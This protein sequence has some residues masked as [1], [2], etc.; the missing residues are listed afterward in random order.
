MD[1]LENEN[2]EIELLLE[3]VHRKYGYDFRSYAKASVRRRIL[4]RLSLSKLSSISEMQHKILYEQSFFETLLIDLSISVT[5]MFRDPQF[6]KVLREEV[7]PNLK[8]YP[9]IKIWNAGCST[10]EEAYSMAILLLEE[11]LYKRAQIYATDFNTAVLEKAKAGAFSTDHIKDYTANY[12]KSGGRKSFSD[13]YTIKQ[14]MAVM[15]KDLKKNI[16]FAD[17]N[18]VT[19]GVFSEMNLI[20]CRNVL[21]YFSKELQ[22]RVIKLFRDSL[23]RNGYLCLG[24]KESLKLSSCASDFEVVAEKEKVY[25]KGAK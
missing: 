16:V 22:N 20:L 1:S 11:N 2:I 5:E 12:E 17:H 10:G 21:I 23:R 25:R 4:N 9:S 15:D 8:S 13:Y 18:L 14:G 19:D 24:L 3:A 6:Y 7:V